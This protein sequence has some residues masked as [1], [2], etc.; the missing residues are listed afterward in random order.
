MTPH[1]ITDHSISVL[2]DNK[3]RVLPASHPNAEALIA[4]LNDDADL[5]VIR[6]L[7]DVRSYLNLLVEGE[8][9]L[10]RDVT[11]GQMTVL[12]QGIQVRQ[13]IADR[14][15]AAFAAGRKPVQLLRFLA[16]IKANT[17]KSNIAD[18]IF[19]WVEA[20]EM[21]ITDD[22]CLIAMKMVKDDYTS[23]HD[24]KFMNDVGTWV[25][26]KVE[27]VDFDRHQLCSRG[28]HFCSPGYLPSFASMNGGYRAGNRILILK[29]NPKDIAAI[30][31]D[32]NFQKGRA[33]GYWIIGEVE[34]DEIER[35]FKTNQYVTA[36][37]PVIEPGVVLHVYE[38][39]DE[40]EDDD[41]D[42]YDDYGYNHDFADYDDEDDGDDYDYYR[43]NP[44][45]VKTAA[46]YV[47]RP[48]PEAD[49]APKVTMI[50]SR[51]VEFTRSEI[52][53]LLSK[54]GSQRGVSRA[55]GIPRTTLQGWITSWN[56]KLDA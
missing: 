18:E 39:E 56:L 27:D 11:S 50:S 10:A 54:H 45:G 7:V 40:D 9:V 13:T 21:P 42:H 16:N 30:P 31:T 20:G 12:Y 5:S 34:E 51:A 43:S 28:L 14:I 23:I 25:E 3:Y 8:V 35:I 36:P 15:V 37:N 38:D 26:E 17:A 49:T 2:V 22:G 52:A 48:E 41:G 33:V 32:Y 24:G 4:A 53:T 6:T 19:D 44:P 47:T 55:T 29:V 1:M 46:D